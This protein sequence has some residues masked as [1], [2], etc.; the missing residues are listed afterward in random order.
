[1]AGMPT[2]YVA[3]YPHTVGGAGPHLWSLIR[4]W[5]EVGIDVCLLS[6]EKHDT[7]TPRLKE[8]GVRFLNAKK[9]WNIPEV[10][11]QIVAGWCSKRFCREAAKFHEKGCKLVWSGCMTFLMNEELVV[12]I[13]HRFNR[14]IVNSAFQE[15]RLRRPLETYGYKPAEIV[16]IPTGFWP[17]EWSFEPKPRDGAFTIG[18]LGR[19]ASDKYDPKLW[20]MYGAIRESIGDVK[21]RVMAWGPGPEKLCG[22]P[23]EWATALTSKQESAETFLH[24][25]HA[26]VHRSGTARENRPRVC[27]EAMACGV[28]V[29]AEARYGWLELIEDGRTGYLCDGDEEFVARA[30]ELAKDE[31]KRLTI[32]NQAREAL[33]EIAPNRTIGLSWRDLLLELSDGKE[34]D[35]DAA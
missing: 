13:G 8:Q 9:R 2:I 25:L 20:R 33:P 12:H 18:R 23:P 11:G 6:K 1:M 17:D 34:A 30:T 27:M 32:C 31:K 35:S 19:D 7:W 10:A 28:P 21:A 16:R 3:G 22:K 26:M 14:V 24:S 29:L 15:A 5:R 4:A